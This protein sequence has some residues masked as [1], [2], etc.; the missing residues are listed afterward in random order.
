VILTPLNLSMKTFHK[1][2]F[3]LPL[4]PFCGL[5]QSN[6]QPGLIVNLKGDTIRGMIDYIEWEY[7]PKSILFKSDS[8]ASP[9]KFTVNQVKFFNVSVGHLAAFQRYVGPIT[10]DKIDADHIQN[11]RDSSFKI[12]T[13]FLRLLQDGPRLKL[14]SYTDNLKTR[15]FIAGNFFEQP[16][17]LTY[18]MYWNTID[19]TDDRTTYETAF[20]GQ[21]YDI[22]VKD[23]VMSPSLKAI[24]S[25]SAYTEPD[26]LK[27]TSAINGISE[28]DLAKNNPTKRGKT[29][30]LLLVLGLILLVVVVETVRVK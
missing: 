20:K 19:A 9:Q 6:Y 12:D 26:I 28:S 2:F 24:I 18:R 11:G 14:F 7:S 25:K 8:L 30:T 4:L 10:T 3:V 1:Y 23:Q 16:V 21:L 17:E 27:I 13:V 5:A 29:H 22:G 15:F